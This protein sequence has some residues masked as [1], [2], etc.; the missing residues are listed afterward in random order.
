MT[1]GRE[2]TRQGK[3][4]KRES[5]SLSHS[6]RVHT[7]FA[8]T[9]PCLLT[10]SLV[11]WLSHPPC[12]YISTL[13]LVVSLSHSSRVHTQN[14]R[15]ET[16]K[17][18]DKTDTRN[19]KKEGKRFAFTLLSRPHF[20]TRFAGTRTYAHPAQNLYNA[21]QTGRVSCCHL[22]CSMLQYVAVFC[23]VLQ[24]VAVRCSAMQ[25]IAWSCTVL[26]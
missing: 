10:P 1:R 19:R 2:M 6:S 7:L 14:K 9:R 21:F 13:S 16:R 24:C 3:E 15:P 5:V 17:K 23:S 20:H 8:F 22:C 11:F 18:N 4:R 25:C 12:P 26:Q